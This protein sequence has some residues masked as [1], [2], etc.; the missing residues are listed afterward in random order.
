MAK[1]KAK[2]NFECYNNGTCP[3][4]DCITN[5]VTPIE[6]LE[7]NRRDLLYTDF[8]SVTL[9]ARPQRARRKGIRL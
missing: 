4:P 1:T 5:G 2:C 6:R 7:Q 8:G 9:K 3:H